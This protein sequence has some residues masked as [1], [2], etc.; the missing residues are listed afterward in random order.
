MKKIRTKRKIEKNQDMDMGKEKFSDRGYKL[1]FSH[2]NMVEYLIKSFVKE[3]FISEIDFSTLKLIKNSFVT[4]TF[5]NRESD[6][7]WKVKISGKKSYIYLLLEFQSTVDKF[8]SLRLLTYIGLFYEHLLKRRKKIEKLPPVFPIVLY[9]G[10][11]R[12]TAP[13]EMEELIDIPF[14]AIKPYIPKFKYYKIAENEF[15]Y[16]ALLEIENLV[17]S[18]FLI[19]TSEVKLLADI[20]VKILHILRKEV[21]TELQRD[22][23]LWL[24]GILRKKKVDIDLDKLDE[25]EVRP[26]L[27]ANL[28]KFE[29][30]IREEEKIEI[31][32]KSL[33]MNLSV[34][35]IVQ[36]TG[37]THDEIEKLKKEG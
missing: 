22:F 18:L 27:L 11:V 5:R 25:M 23:G 34:E 6:L 37:L 14:H 15:S 31:A 3:E 10:D 8:M 26:M 16:E 28:E 29:Q 12:W 9:N 35:Q 2:P 24:R 32:K 7:I 33:Q 17:S 13:L 1:L 20:I 36:L 19:E 30:E 21:N 4:K